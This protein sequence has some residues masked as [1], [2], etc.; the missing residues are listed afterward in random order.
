MAGDSD[1]RRL[2]PNAPCTDGAPPSHGPDLRVP[3]ATQ[4]WQA[5]HAAFFEAYNADVEK[6]GLLLAEHRAF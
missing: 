5:E 2:G 3:D 4:R 6:N 1:Q